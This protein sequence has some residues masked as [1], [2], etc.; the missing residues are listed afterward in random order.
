MAFAGPY[1]QG[2]L[3]AK[4]QLPTQ[5]DL[6]RQAFGERAGVIIRA[7]SNHNLEAA[8]LRAATHG[9]PAQVVGV[10]GNALDVEGSLALTTMTERRANGLQRALSAPEA[11]AAS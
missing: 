7:L 10:G 3:S 6:R 8:P 1:I 2:K 4:V 9:A 11:T 5:D